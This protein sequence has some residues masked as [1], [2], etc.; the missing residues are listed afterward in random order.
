MATKTFSTIIAAAVMAIAIGAAGPA[1]SVE[2]KDNAKF[3]KQLKLPAD[4]LKGSEADHKVP[5]KWL[6]AARKEGEV[7]ITGTWDPKQFRNF[8]TP[9]KERFPFIKLTYLRGTKFDRGL[10]PLLA[11]KQ[12]RYITDVVISIGAFYQQMKDGG[13]LEDLRSLP[14]FK[15]LPKPFRDDDS[16]TWV[17]QKVTYRCIG[18]NTK[19][20]KTSDLPKTWDDILTNPRWRDGKLALNNYPHSWLLPL[21]GLKGKEWAKDF[22]IKLFAIKPQLR[23][24]GQT[25]SVGLVAAGEF[26]A[27]IL[28][29]AFRTRQYVDRGAPVGFHCP[30][31]VPVGPAQL[32]VMKGSPRV[33][34]AK[35]FA[36]WILSKEGQTAQF[37]VAAIAPSHKDLQRREF[38]PFPDAVLGKKL[39]FRYQHL[40]ENENPELVR[41]W[42]RLWDKGTGQKYELFSATVK[43]TKRKGRRITVSHKGK[44]R[45]LKVSGRRTKV[46][47]D[48]APNSRK[49][50]KV[51]MTC[52]IL[53]SIT[54]KEPKEM[55]CK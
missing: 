34:A 55:A 4:F 43:A 8:T 3:L 27:V 46:T 50:I 18:Y 28:A 35:I 22:M 40:V 30:E 48:G 13:A 42:N 29:A 12:G 21:W 51:G 1:F 38:L 16:G 32:A 2:P 17:G 25:A 45:K 14:N 31:P 36:N 23:K 6:E 49:A 53:Y 37:A 39:A 19:L 33:N 54:D 41:F 9:F 52:K 44:D 15:N 24:E 7:K 5:A 20:V 26:D 11:F 47:I 10:K